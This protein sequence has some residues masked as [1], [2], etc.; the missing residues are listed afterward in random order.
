MKNQPKAAMVNGFTAQ[1]MKTVTPMPRQCSRTCIIDAKSIF[2]SIGTIMSQIRTATG[3]LTCATSARPIA[4]NR[5]GKIEPRAMPATM[6]SAT[7]RVR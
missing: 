6:Q 2:S 5:S 3:R 7:Q 1:L 4:W